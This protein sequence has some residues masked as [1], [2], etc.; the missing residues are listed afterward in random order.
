MLWETMLPKEIEDNASHEE[1]AEF[2]RHKISQRTALEIKR[3]LHRF[4]VTEQECMLS[5]L[6][7]RTD[8]KVCCMIYSDRVR[9]LHVS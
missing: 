9:L 7:K 8:S 2:V 5:K 3:E 4:W 6:A 1:I